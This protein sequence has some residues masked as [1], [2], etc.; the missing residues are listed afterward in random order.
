M[1]APVDYYV[2]KYEVTIGRKH[3][4][5]TLDLELPEAYANV[6]RL[7]AKIAYNF[8]KKCF[9]LHVLG[10]NGIT[11]Y[12]GEET[13]A[14]FPADGPMKLTTRT[15][16]IVGETT[17]TFLMPDPYRLPRKPAPPGA[18]GAG[19][20]AAAAGEGGSPVQEGR[21]RS[22]S[23]GEEEGGDGDAAMDDT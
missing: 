6:S 12:Y 23:P 9:E 3:K 8:S 21:G 16:F 1:Q 2:R 18:S 14:R 19:G 22:G 17:F 7:H 11:M 15:R 20:A 5:S 13:E 10:K 4:G